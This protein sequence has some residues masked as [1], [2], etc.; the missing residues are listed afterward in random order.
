MDDEHVLALVEAVH[1]AYGNAVRGFAANTA[2][3]DDVSQFSTP[4][5]L[6]SEILAKS[7]R[8]GIQLLSHGLPQGCVRRESAAHSTAAGASLDRRTMIR[9]TSLLHKLDCQYLCRPVRQGHCYAC[10][11][12]ELRRAPPGDDGEAP[13]RVQGSHPHVL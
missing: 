7:L 10:T 1:R 8:E 6:E 4:K 11:C 5:F 9:T 3:V 2:I 13:A 12:Y